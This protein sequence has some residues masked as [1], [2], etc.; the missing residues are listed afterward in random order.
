M[1]VGDSECAPQG[2]GGTLPAPS[3]PSYHCADTCDFTVAPRPAASMNAH[4]LLMTSPTSHVVTEPHLTKSG[5]H[6]WWEP[7]DWLIG[8]ICVRETEVFL[9]S[10]TLWDSSAEGRLA[11]VLRHTPQRHKAKVGEFLKCFD[12]LQAVTGE[13]LN[14]PECDLL[15]VAIY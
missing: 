5:F 1:V 9:V 12:P 15:T 11:T 2:L 4:G 13:V 10:S 6:G 7:L 14:P 8:S 3:M